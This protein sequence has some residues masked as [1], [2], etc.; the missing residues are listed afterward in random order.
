MGPP[1]G[2]FC[3]ITLTSCCVKKCVYLYS[4]FYGRYQIKTTCWN[5]ITSIQHLL[6]Y[7]CNEQWPG[8][9]FDK[10]VLC[11]MNNLFIV[12]ILCWIKR[13]FRDFYYCVTVRGSRPGKNVQLSENEIRGLCLK[14][15][16]IFLSQP[17]LLEL[18]AP[19]KICGLWY[20]HL[21]LLTR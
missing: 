13:L 1:W 4:R 2:A 21:T 19:L 16:E 7:F 20:I 9:P 6:L 18:E 17:I 3:Q 5:N 14:S 10:L 8:Q 11:V 15:R 12:L